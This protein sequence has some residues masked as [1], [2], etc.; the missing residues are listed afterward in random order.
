MRPVPNS[1]RGSK[2]NLTGLRVDAERSLAP[3]SGYDTDQK[4]TT[5]ATLLNVRDVRDA[6][7]CAITAL[8]G[9]VSGFDT[10][11]RR[12]VLPALQKPFADVDC[13]LEAL[14]GSVSAAG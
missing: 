14:R 9:A 10:Q 13:A 6:V 11:K 12:E 4:R 8:Q 1:T 7:A 2:I 5:G 3:L